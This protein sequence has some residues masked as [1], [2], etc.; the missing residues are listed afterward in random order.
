MILK[1]GKIIAA[2]LVLILMPLISVRAKEKSEMGFSV[3]PA[4]FNL[5][6]VGKRSAS[7]ILA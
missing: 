4:I 3:E 6:P 5:N 7:I 1:K 2:V